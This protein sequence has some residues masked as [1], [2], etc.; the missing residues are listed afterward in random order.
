MS[1]ERKAKEVLLALRL[2]KF[3]SKDEILEAY[4]NVVPFGRNASGRNI[5]GV[6]AAAKGV[7][8][9]DAKELTLPQAAFLAGL[10]Q[11]PFRYTPFTS[12]GELKTIYLRA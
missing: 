5:A 7:F 12:K 3:F 4:I 11:S 6:Q 9:V 8:G 1:F 10:P 2:E